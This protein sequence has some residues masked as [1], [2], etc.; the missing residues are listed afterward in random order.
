MSLTVD[1]VMPWVDGADPVWLEEKRKYDPDEGE[2]AD[3]NRY[4]DWGLL[5][6]WF[7]SVEKY[8]PWVNQI[9]FITHGHLPAWLNTENPKLH[10]VKHE[11]YIP[12]EFLPVFSSHP[13]ELNMHRIESLSE[14]FIYSND[15]LFFLSDTLPSDYF[16]DGKPVDLAE[17]APFCC[18]EGGIDRIIANDIAVLNKHFKK[19]EVVK[20]NRRIWFSLKAPRA[21]LKNLYMLPIK[22]FSAF[23]NPHMMQ[24]FLKSTLEEVWD[25]E[26]ELLS[27]T[28]AHRFRNN[29]DVNQWL[30]RYWQYA[31]GNFSPSAETKGMFFSIGRDDAAI[32]EAIRGHKYKTVCLSDDTAE[33]DFEKEKDFLLGLFQEILPDKCS[34][35]K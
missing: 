19:R 12:R 17:E 8:A 33:I 32:K 27:R 3:I 7:R 11:D 15:D 2:D 10:I 25:E 4:R 22:A 35:E 14:H 18:F 20:R 13:L 31:K 9:H 29:E 5:K 6:F 23:A 21:A 26:E 28:S 16:V 30:F 1:I 24:P 34:F